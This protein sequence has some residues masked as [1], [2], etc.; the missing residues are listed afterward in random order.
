MSH[1]SSLGRRLAR[2]EADDRLGHPLLHER[3]R[4]LLV[5]APDLTDHDDRLGAGIV[6]EGG[7]AINEVSPDY[8]VASDPDAGA[9]PDAVAGHLIDHLVGKGA[10]PRHEPNP[11]WAADVAGDDAHLGLS[12]RDQ[13]GT[14]GTDQ[15]GS[16]GAHER[17]DPTH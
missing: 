1:P 2:D 4:T 10:A 11:S 14:V 9:L 3:C 17:H 7:E 5:G 6:L 8:G 12:G 16:A 13:A 15:P